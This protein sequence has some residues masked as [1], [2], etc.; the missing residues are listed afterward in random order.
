MSKDMPGHARYRHAN[1]GCT[2][3]RDEAAE[4]GWNHEYITLV[5]LPGR[6]FFAF[7]CRVAGTAIDD[8]SIQ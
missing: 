7:F 4:L 3:D 6:V 1:E 8:Q 2:S 5:P